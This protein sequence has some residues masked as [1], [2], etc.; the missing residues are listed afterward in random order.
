MSEAEDVFDKVQNNSLRSYDIPLLLKRLRQDARNG[1]IELTPK[2]IEWF[3]VYEF[4]LQQL[5]LKM[6]NASADTHPGDW[7]NTVND[8]S[9]IK[10]IIDEMEEKGVIT[11]ANWNV[12]SLALFTIPNGEI[13]RRHVCCLINTHL[14]S[15][16][17][18]Q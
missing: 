13:Y 10:A 17:G 6:G 12:G 3:S 9:K 15:L 5:E 1:R 2:D 11:N 16:Y 8:F 4:A 7:R 14:A 18:N